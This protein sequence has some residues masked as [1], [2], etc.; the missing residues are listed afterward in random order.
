MIKQKKK[1]KE[2]K[3]MVADFVVLHFFFAVSLIYCI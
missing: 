2:R 1:K 3:A